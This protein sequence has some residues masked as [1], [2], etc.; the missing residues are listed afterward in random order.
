MIHVVVCGCIILID[1][2]STSLNN[3]SVYKPEFDCSQSDSG[4]K[5][6]KLIAQPRHF[7]DQFTASD[8]VAYVTRSLVRHT[9]SGK[10]SMHVNASVKPNVVHRKQKVNS[11]SRDSDSIYREA[12]CKT[13]TR[14]SRKRSMASDD[15]SGDSDYVPQWKPLPAP[16]RTRVIAAEVARTPTVL[17]LNQLPMIVQRAWTVIDKADASYVLESFLQDVVLDAVHDVSRFTGTYEE[18]RDAI[19]SHVLECVRADVMEKK[20]ILA[21]SKYERDYHWAMEQRRFEK[22]QQRMRARKALHGS[23]DDDS[24]SDPM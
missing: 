16:S 14:P 6:E 21:E 22:Q 7:A 10:D 9:S 3:E 4:D 15:S 23:S 19:I 20:R 1:S 5:S 18:K 24:F 13:R 12:R 8:C 17:P 11:S 2:G